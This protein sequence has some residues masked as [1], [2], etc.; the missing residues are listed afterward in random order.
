[1]RVQSSHALVAPKV[2]NISLSLH[3]KHILDVYTLNLWCI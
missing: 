1:M 3:V 2:E